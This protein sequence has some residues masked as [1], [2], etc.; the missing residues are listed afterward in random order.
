MHGDETIMSRRKK[1]GRVFRTRAGKLGR[2]VYRGGRRVGF[3]LVK[4]FKKEFV[5]GFKRGLRGK[6]HRRVEYSPYGS[7]GT[8]HGNVWKKNR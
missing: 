2:Y 8:W 1:F 5:K 6:S 4:E 3:E 7:R